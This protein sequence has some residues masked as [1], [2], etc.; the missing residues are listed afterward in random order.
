MIHVLAAGLTDIGKKRDGNED[1]YLIDEARQLYVVADGM[2][3][4]LAGE[5]ASG[6]VVET[7]KSF[8]EHSDA[9]SLTISDDA[10]SPD[11]NQLAQGIREA[12]TAVR[13][14]AQENIECR[15]MGSTLAAAYFTDR[16]VMVANV[17]DS[18]IYLVHDGAIELISVMH[19]VAAEIAATRPERAH[20]ID[21][22]I[23]HMLTRAIGSADDVVS[24]IS[25]LQCF[26]ND[27][28]VLCSDGLSNKVT[29][30][31]IA[32]SVTE[33]TPQDACRYLVDLANERGGDDNIT[34]V[35]I[36]VTGVDAHQHP[37]RRL[38]VQVLE[39]VKKYIADNL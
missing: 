10:L 9:A 37:L 34:V 16:T 11:A 13:A 4:H 7:L 17:G 27:V 20:M 29:M 28:F 39:K 25:E 22:K 5:V 38:C 6:L 2:G 12:N 35:I 31:E 36:R 24:D 14:R 23:L 8:F 33:S 18:P 15:G 26:K 3:G 1:A 19:T 32:R 30:D 21:E